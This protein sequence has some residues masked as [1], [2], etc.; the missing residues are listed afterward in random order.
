MAKEKFIA[1][2]GAGSELLHEPFLLHDVV[3]RQSKDGRPFLLA[4]LRDRTG[5]INGVFWDVPLTIDAWVRPGLAVLISGKVNTYKDNL[6][7]NISDIARANG[8]DMADFLPASRRPKAEMEDELSQ[9]IASLTDP[10]QTLTAHLLLEGPLAAPFAIAPAARGMHHAYVG[11]LLE[12]SLSM[13]ALA[14]HL[15]SQHSFVNRD[16]LVCGTLLHDLGKSLEYSLNDGIG[17]TDDGRL[18]GHIVRGVVVVEQA[19]AELHFPAAEL[20]QLVHLLVSHHGTYEWGSPVLPK[21]I[22]AVLLH[23]I[24]LLDSRVAGF[25]DHVGHDSGNE[26]WTARRSEMFGTELQRPAGFDWSSGSDDESP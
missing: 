21:T 17:V 22:E 9:V 26:A 25:M 18:V 1:N 12:H 13:A 20:Q 16:L 11:G 19:A 24:D 14:G 8:V 10:W 3:R 2:L 7:I 5:Q 4:I 23:Q 15:A 6:Q